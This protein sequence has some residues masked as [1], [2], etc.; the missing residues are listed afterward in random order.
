MRRLSVAVAAPVVAALCASGLVVGWAGTAA[1]VTPT[2][3]S[4]VACTKVKFNNSTGE[5]VVS[6]CYNA[7][8]AS[9]GKSFKDLVAMSAETLLGGG[10]LSWSPGPVGG[11]TVTTSALTSTTG[12]GTCPSKDTE[13][14]YEGTVT[15]VS[16]T[17]NPATSGDDVFVDVCL[18]TTKS[19]ALKV[20]F[21]PG[22]A[23][24][25]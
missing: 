14:A 4:S 3:G 10:T 2:A 23:G 25:F 9:T 19:G 5:A 21:A 6:K 7:S 13:A 17:G 11:A 15:G 20:S 16:G 8:G 12:A 1:A 22:T 18:S 24:E